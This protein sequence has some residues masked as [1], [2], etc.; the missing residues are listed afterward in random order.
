MLSDSEPM[1]TQS[2]DISCGKRKVTKKSQQ[3]KP[4]NAKHRL[5][6]QEE[7][8]KYKDNEI[9]LVLEESLQESEFGK[10]VKKRFSA[11][12]DH[13]YGIFT[14]P[15]EAKGLCRWTH[16]KFSLSGHANIGDVDS[17]IFR[18]AII[19]YPL[20]QLISHLY[21][22][23]DGLEFKS[24]RE[25]YTA[26]NEL[27]VRSNSFPIGTRISLLLIGWEKFMIQIDSAPVSQSPQS[28]QPIYDLYDQVSGVGCIY[29]NLFCL[30]PKLL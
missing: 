23:A 28:G 16:R 13:K 10:E 19:V 22:S 26:T 9:S 15:C 3:K 11:N 4:S 5:D 27:L 18:V 12:T 30:K 21:S 6:T 14:H 17:A 7:R 2:S 29:F 20:Q 8:G 25:E 1:L 24:F